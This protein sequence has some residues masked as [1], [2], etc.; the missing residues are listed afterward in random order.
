MTKIYGDQHAVHEVSFEAQSGKVLGF[1]GPNGAGKSTT[2]K[3]ITGFLPPSSGIASVCGYDV[4]TAP[5]EARR[6]I[7]YLPE[8]NHSHKEMY[9]H[10]ARIRLRPSFFPFTEP[11]AEVD[12][13]CFV[14]NAQGCSVC[15]YSGLV[16]IM[17][18]GIVEPQVL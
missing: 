18:C 13:T 15:K 10:D 1:L 11:S 4:E 7:G 3:I 2:M 14:C 9:G 6:R 8:S 17:G 16:E 5:M 12:V